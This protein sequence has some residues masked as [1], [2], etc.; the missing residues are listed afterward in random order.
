M[1]LTWVKQKQDENNIYATKQS[2][3][4]HQTLINERNHRYINIGGKETTA[5][6]ARAIIWREVKY[7]LTFP[8]INK[9]MAKWWWERLN[10]VDAFIDRA[11]P[12]SIPIANMYNTPK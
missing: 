10:L 11:E 3:N 7:H 6:R 8:H 1:A 4:P 9:H 12:K 5:Y 2:S